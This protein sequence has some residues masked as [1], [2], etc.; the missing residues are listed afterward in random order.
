MR[1]NLAWIN[2]ANSDRGGLRGLRQRLRVPQKSVKKYQK[3]G[4]TQLP[5]SW[6][7]PQARSGAEPQRRRR[8]NRLVT[9]VSA[10]SQPFLMQNKV[11]LFSENTIQI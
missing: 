1:E 8:R 5:A 6:T 3:S 9:R 10:V 2:Q 7:R 4:Q 11:V